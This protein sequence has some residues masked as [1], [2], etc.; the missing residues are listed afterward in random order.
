MSNKCSNQQF[1]F[2]NC[3]GSVLLGISILG[4]STPLMAGD[5]EDVARMYGRLTGTIPTNT[6]L[7]SY[8]DVN[9]DM[10][11]LS[12][13]SLADPAEKIALDIINSSD[14]F[15]NVVLKNFAARWT[16]EAQDIFVPLNDYSATVIGMIRDADHP[17]NPVDFRDVLSGDI[18]YVGVA[19][20]LPARSNFNN[21]HY[22]ALEDLGLAAGSLKEETV[23]ERRAQSVETGLDPLATAGVMTTRAGSVAFYSGGTN[24]AMFRFTLMNHLCT[25][26][27]PL[28]DTSRVPDRVRRDVSR[29]PGGDSR[30][31]MNACVG[32]HAGMDGM[33]GAFAKYELDKNGTADDPSDDYLR[34]DDFANNDAETD[35][36][37]NG[38]DANGV[39]LKHNINPNN[40]KDGYI[41][42]NDSWVNY[43]RNGQNQLLGW[44]DPASLAA[45]GI[46]VDAK[47]HTHGNGAKSLG[48]ELA[49]TRAF[50]TCQ[51]KKAFKHI[52]LRDPD[53]FAADRT[54][55]NSIADHFENNG[56]NMKHVFAKVA[57]YCRTPQ[58]E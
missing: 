7:D 5:R 17:T 26:L 6:T 42:T 21:N 24:R 37:K 22:A 49:Q 53:V 39:S 1:S 54:Q 30:I 32:C 45:A 27:E 11:D 8:L 3:L 57:A 2:R 36:D 31:Y 16:N 20:G 51:V 13:S 29:S 9:G 55:V 12:G 38:F 47:G 33:A 46:T 56:G 15:Y 44:A 34:Y 18:I 19:P 50:S 52:C 41:T 4:T 28:K 48:V 58:S 23:L 35:T 14:S 40:F 43:W 25:D 10:I